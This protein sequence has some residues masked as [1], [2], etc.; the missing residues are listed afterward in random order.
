MGQ[1]RPPGVVPHAADPQIVKGSVKISF[2]PTA[3]VL[4]YPVFAEV[5]VTRVLNRDEFRRHC[6]RYRT[7]EGILQHLE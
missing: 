4:P 6:D 1:T 7:R 3:R 5:Y 2:T